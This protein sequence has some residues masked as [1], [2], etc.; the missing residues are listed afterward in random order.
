R[1]T[2]GGDTVVVQPAAYADGLRAVGLFSEQ[3]NTPWAAVANHGEFWEVVWARG[4]QTRLEAHD[5]EVLRLVARLHRGLGRELPEPLLPQ[6]LRTVGRVFD[7]TRAS[8]FA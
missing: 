1:R 8:S 7:E 5:L 3:A 6:Q 4:S 2:R